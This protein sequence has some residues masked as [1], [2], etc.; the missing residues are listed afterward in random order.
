M[1]VSTQPL[2]NFKLSLS[3]PTPRTKTSQAFISYTQNRRHPCSAYKA[4]F[5]AN[6]PLFPELSLLSGRGLKF[7]VGVGKE[8]SSGE[9]DVSLVSDAR[10]QEDFSWFSPWEA[11]YSGMTLVPP[12]V[13]TISLQLPELS[14][15]T[16]WFN[17]SAIQLGLVVSGSLYGA[18]LGSLLVYPIADFLWR[19]RELI[20][21]AVLYML[22]ALITAYAPSLG[23]LLAGRLFMALVLVDH[24]MLWEK[25]HQCRGTDR[26]TSLGRR[27]FSGVEGEYSGDSG[28]DAF[29]VHGAP[30]PLDRSGDQTCSNG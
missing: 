25:Y 10:N 24:G 26:V 4:H 3:R 9:E 18:L 19:T 5:K 14:T 30:M 6:F 8:Y 27:L 21:A 29:V 12:L 20:M 11:C 16:T 15:G 1:A 23:F 28:A 7:N 13:P 2:F 22:G 17:L